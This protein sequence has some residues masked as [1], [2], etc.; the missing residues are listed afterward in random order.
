M[1]GQ[2][3]VWEVSWARSSMVHGQG[4]EPHRH[5]F[6]LLLYPAAGVLTTTTERGTW[7]APAN[8]A[9]WTPPDFEHQHRAYGDTEVRLLQVPAERCHTLPAEP[10]VFAVSPL[11]REAL[12]VLTGERELREGH[13]GALQQVVIEELIDSPV[14][15]LYLPRPADDRLRAVTDRLHADPADPSTL[16]EFGRAV[17][18]SER[19]LSRLFQAELGMSF[20]QWRSLLRVQ[21]ALVRLAEGE[22]VIDTAARLGWS[23]P[24]S[25]I[26][27][28]SALIGQTPGRYRADLRS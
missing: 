24:T 4:V 16:A 19:T 10:T 12:L 3:A 22:P 25:F 15:D 6:G 18:A 11:L 17:G 23:N 7:V 21:H 5:D 27:A 8:R 28:F 20:H 13:R 14:Q 9:T 2:G 1:T 26:E